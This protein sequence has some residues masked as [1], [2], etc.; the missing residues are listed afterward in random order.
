ME[1]STARQILGLP[2]D[3]HLLLFGTFGENSAPH[4]GFD[5]LQ[6]ALKHLRDQ[7]D[8]LQLVVFGQN[9]PRKPIEL[10]FPTHYMGHLHDDVS[11]RM[12]YNAVDVLVIP[13]RKDNLP[14]TGVEAMACGTP[15]VAFD[16]CGLP[17]IVKHQ[18]T[19]YLAK[20][21]DTEDLA[22]GVQW[23]L[24]DSERY[25]KLST[26]ARDD[27]VARFSYPVVARQYMQVYESAVAFN[28]PTSQ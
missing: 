10:G 22:R 14:N 15:V 3:G 28:H 24:Q 8:G 12:L 23:V 16:T 19:G 17:D 9:E 26:Q 7:M 11:L 1:M 25:A 2:A 13:S 27:A 18:E 20:A 5:L 21:F 4:K 6:S